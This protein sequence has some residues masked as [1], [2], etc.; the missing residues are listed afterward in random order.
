MV[1]EVVSTPT[2]DYAE[3]WAV[4]VVLVRVLQSAGLKVDVRDRLPLFRL[5]H[6]V[7][8]RIT[9]TRSFNILQLIQALVHMRM[10]GMEPAHDGKK[11]T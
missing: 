7:S 9:G 10:K 2:K 4:Q 6:T 5:W 1:N 3:Y 11:Y 8:T